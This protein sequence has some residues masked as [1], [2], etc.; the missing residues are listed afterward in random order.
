M[1]RITLILLILSV[2]PFEIMAQEAEESG[3]SPKMAAFKDYC[4]R[5]ANAAASCDAD[6]LA[7]C[8]E[9]WEPAEYDANGN[10]TKAEK[11]IYN[12]EE[13]HYSAFSDMECSDTTN[14]EIVGM[15]FGFMP[16]AVD[17]W[18]TNR[19]ETVELAD[20]NMLRD[21]QKHLEY[22][23][24]AL[25]ANSKATY[26]TRGSGL[27]EIFVVAEK[28]GQLTLSAHATEKN[29]KKEILKETDLADNSGNQTAQLSWNMERNGTI[30]LTIENLSDKS[31]SFIMVKKL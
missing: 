14:E 13:I 17:S 25:K 23:V 11:F 28:D 1:K 27:I 15:H 24:R 12:D 19:C 22:A 29:Y 4:T 5:A 30:E 31:I 8:I 9:N 7:A 18:I 10:E 6:E 20:A 21:G 2:L 26:T 3:L 16:Q